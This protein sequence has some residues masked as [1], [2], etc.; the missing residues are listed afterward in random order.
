MPKRIVVCLLCLFVAMLLQAQGD[1][2]DFVVSDLPPLEYSELGVAKGY[3]VDIIRA[4]FKRMGLNVK[5]DFFPWLRCLEM[6]KSH[7]VR[8]ILSLHR[9]PEREDYLIFPAENLSVC[10]QVLFVQKGKEFVLTNIQDLAGKKLGITKGHSYGAEFDKLLR[11]RLIT[12]D[13][14]VSD[15]AGF[16][17]LTLG[18]F[19]GFICD[20]SVGLSY[21]KTLGLQDKV[22]ML[23][24]V[25][26]SAKLYAAFDKT[27]ENAALVARFD[28][29]LRE[30]K[31]S[32]EWQKIIDYYLQ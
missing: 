3:H 23:P 5:F 24:F 19:D 11:D 13:E 27:S 12:I 25:V 17:K 1:T 21:V 32:G 14:G 2:I 10:E 31:K 28:V 9:L 29:A 16:N 7:Q 20:H 6:I 15:V 8:A 22:I 18:R 30:L 4:T 26:S